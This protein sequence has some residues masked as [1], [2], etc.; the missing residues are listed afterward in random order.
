MRKIIKQEDGKLIVPIAIHE[1]DRII[2]GFTEME[3]NHK[4]Y[5]KMLAE[6]EREQKIEAEVQEKLA[7]SEDSHE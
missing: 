1:K 3:P 5:P 6:Y 4:D 2:D 7:E